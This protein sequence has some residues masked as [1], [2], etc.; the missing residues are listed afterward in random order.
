MFRLPI[1]K[2]HQEHI[3]LL[4]HRLPVHQA[5][6]AAAAA[7]LQE[8]VVVEAAEDLEADHPEV[9]KLFVNE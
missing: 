3:S 8:V 7:A 6:G 1:Q 2:D 4:H 9:I 5:Q